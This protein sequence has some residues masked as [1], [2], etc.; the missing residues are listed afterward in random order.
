MLA[1]NSGRLLR[2][3]IQLATAAEPNVAVLCRL[4]DKLLPS[5]HTQAI[6]AEL[7]MRRP[8]EDADP[9]FL[10][11]LAD[12]WAERQA[13]KGVPLVPDSANN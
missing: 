10:A 6:Q 4:L 8:F 11:K 9:A 1:A 13:A 7:N 3:A 12:E 2:K 5:M